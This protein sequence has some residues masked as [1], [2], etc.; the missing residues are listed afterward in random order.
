M[1]IGYCIEDNR[2]KEVEDPIAHFADL[3]WIDLL[4]PTPEEKTTLQCH[5][6]IDLPTREEMAEIEVSARLY[7]EGEAI[8]MTATL[9][10]NAETPLPE[11][12][13][14]T[15]ILHG[16][17]LIS[18]RYHRP[19]AFETFPK[20]AARSELGCMDGTT[21]LMALLEAVVERLADLTE[22]EAMAND[23]ISRQIFRP[24][25]RDIRVSRDYRAVLEAIGQSGDMTA[26]LL[27]SLVTLDRLVTFMM[28]HA[29]QSGHGGLKGRLKSLARDIHSLSE[30]SLFL[31][32]KASFLLE[33]T[34]GMINI[35]QNAIIKIFS[36]AA[37]I[38]LPPTL[39]ASIYGMNFRFMP[40]LGWPFGY[41]FAIGL[42]IVSALI[43]FW[44]FKR[45]GWL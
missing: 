38:F 1:I 17:R 7:Q 16:R 19:R 25:N 9:I 41:P 22:R 13:P 6:M 35:E 27:E 18:V 15:F 4:E 3:V 42:M 24:D 39:V 40:E 10:A 45:K 2:L 30:H 28:L 20:R 21:T 31:S 23:T 37:V 5:L 36:V 11:K 12:A 43:P 44:Y 14:V 33:A 8:F 34:L 26:L 29:I 32:Q